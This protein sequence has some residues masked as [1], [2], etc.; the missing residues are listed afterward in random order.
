MAKRVFAFGCSFTEYQWPTWADF[1]GRTY[2]NKGY[3]YYNFGNSGAGNY[4]ILASLFAADTKYKF[5]KDDIILVMWSSWTRDDR[6]VLDYMWRVP[7]DPNK[8]LRGEWTKRGNILNITEPVENHYDAIGSRA[9]TDWCLENDIVK[10]LLAIKAAR[11]MYNINFEDTILAHEGSIVESEMEVNSVEHRIF[12][13]YL[14]VTGS[15]KWKENNWNQIMQLEHLCPYNDPLHEGVKMQDGHPLPLQHAWY[16]KDKT[17][18][19][20]DESTVNYAH[21][22]QDYMRRVVSEGNNKGD[23]Q[24]RHSADLKEY[25]AGTY[26]DLWK[27]DIFIDLLDAL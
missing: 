4:Y 18:F 2:H 21:R 24:D 26:I 10:N 13:K 3:E 23:F 9:L 14:K 22:F 25:T 11:S 27:D 5:D 20:L 6:Y 8:R 19:T 12:E 17:P 15:E 1:I 7:D 16:V